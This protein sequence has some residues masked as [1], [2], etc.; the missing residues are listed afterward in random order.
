MSDDEP[1]KAGEIIP[2]DVL[3]AA[4]DMKRKSQAANAPPG[5][6]QHRK[7]SAKGRRASRGPAPSFKP[8]QFSDRQATAEGRSEAFVMSWVILIEAVDAARILTPLQFLHLLMALG[9]VLRPAFT[10]NEARLAQTAIEIVAADPG[11]ALISAD[12]D[13]DIPL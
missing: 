3:V 12:P 7:A 9:R 4:R 13:D 11:A 5:S 10:P 8:G 1:N 2:N 6:A